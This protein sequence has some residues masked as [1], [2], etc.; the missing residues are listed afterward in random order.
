MLIKPPIRKQDSWG[1]GEFHASR[2]NRLHQ[3]I[4]FCCHP[5]SDVCSTVT[6]L[7]TKIGYPYGDDM[8]F[9][10]V[11]VTDN[12]GLSHR[13]FYVLPSIDLGDVVSI[14]DALGTSQELGERYPDITEHFHYEIKEGDKY[15]NPEDFL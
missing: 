4:D 1:S 6:G 5:G 7:I 10:Y 13:Y 8:R 9:K 15:L 11:Q 12:K 3:G 14:G 2:G